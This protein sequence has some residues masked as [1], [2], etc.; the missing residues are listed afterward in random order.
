ME[1][2]AGRV[3]LITGAGSGIGRAMARAVA[4]EGARVAALDIDA[5]LLDALAVDL[6]G[7][8]LACA[9]ADV[10]DLA[11]VRAAV[12]RLEAEAGPTDVLIACAGI[13]RETS[14]L[15]FRAEDVADQVRVNLVGVANC[16]DAVLPG[17]RQRQRGHLVAVSSLASYH[18]VPLM[19]GYCAS[20]AGLNALL[21]ALRVELR[22]LGVTVT[23]LCPGWVRTPLTQPLDL[24]PVRM[25]NVEEAARRMLGAVRARKR[26]LAF[27][28]R[29]AWQV[30][31][32]RY[33]PRSLSDR[34]AARLLAWARARKK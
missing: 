33:L 11:A 21:D 20:K 6:H 22:P 31:A 16:I 17:M 13:G 32:L 2:F 24:P 25:M 34:V 23:T 7:K 28:A 12:A 1:T 19:G 27:P 8:P 5:G 10:T 14:A 26:F 29:S 15:T 30:R 9:A 4:A 18:G 3:V